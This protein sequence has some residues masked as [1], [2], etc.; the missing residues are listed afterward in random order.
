MS[1]C[2]RQAFDID[3]LDC[4][5]FAKVIYLPN[6]L[7]GFSSQPPDQINSAAMQI[8]GP[9]ENEPLDV[10]GTRSAFEALAAVINEDE[11]RQGKAA[12]SV[13]EI[14]MGFLMVANETMCR[15][16]RALTQMKVCSGNDRG[17]HV[18]NRLFQRFICVENC[19]MKIRG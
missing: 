3:A 13:D 19:Y 7:S 10:V 18:Y 11:V 16:I 9:Q 1:R 5:P 17:L 8:F 12:K 6:F 4:R 14:A 2:Y 15:P